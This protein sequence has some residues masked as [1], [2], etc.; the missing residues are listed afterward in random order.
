MSPVVIEPPPG[1]FKIEL[2]FT[3]S[4]DPEITCIVCNQPGCDLAVT[5][6]D[7]RHHRITMGKHSAC[8]WVMAKHRVVSEP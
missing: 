6:Y 5:V 7:R 4:G 2:D 3:P 1:T 8:T